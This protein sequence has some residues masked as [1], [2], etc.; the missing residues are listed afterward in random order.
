[1]DIRLKIKM[2]CARR[3]NDA[4]YQRYRRRSVTGRHAILIHRRHMEYQRSRGMFLRF[5]VAGQ[6]LSHGPI[7]LRSPVR[8]RSPADEFYG[9]RDVMRM[10]E[11]EEFRQL[12]RRR[13]MPVPPK[14]GLSTPN[15]DQRG[16]SRASS[17]SS[18]EMQRLP[19]FVQKQIG[20]YSPR[21]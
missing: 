10:P 5:G 16:F 11:P 13:A 20:H 19:C 12:C 6:P 8:E 9:Q 2:R 21:E 3:Q 1:M 18:W 15:L 14:F 4:T 17:T 7:V